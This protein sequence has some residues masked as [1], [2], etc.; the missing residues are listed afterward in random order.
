MNINQENL[1]KLYTYHPPE[2][3]QRAAKHKAIND[4]AIAFAQAIC[5]Q[6]DN[7]AEATVI[8]RR[9]QEVRMLAN[10]AVCFE[11]CDISYRKLFE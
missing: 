9:I 3:D 2:S 4:A 11:D 6:I 5:S 10:A 8:L 1:K 7:P